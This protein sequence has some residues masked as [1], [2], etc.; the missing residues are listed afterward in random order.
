[1]TR[2]EYPVGRIELT[3]EIARDESDVSIE[4]ELAIGERAD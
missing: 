4:Q 2:Y 1:M 3:N